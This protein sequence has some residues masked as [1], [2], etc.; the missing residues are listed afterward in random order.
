MSLS[1]SHSLL[2]VSSVSRPCLAFFS[3]TTPSPRKPT[4][5]KPRRFVHH[6]ILLDPGTTAPPPP[7]HH[8]VPPP[9]AAAARRFPARR[10]G[11]AQHGGAVGAVQRRD[12]RRR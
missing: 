1:V 4:S 7:I 10:R 9:P 11:G 5:H 12:V 3:I 8:A 6:G 2:T